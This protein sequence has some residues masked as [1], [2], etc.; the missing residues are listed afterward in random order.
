VRNKAPNW[1]DRE[2]RGG[3]KK[4]YPG[5]SPGARGGENV[6]IKIIFLQR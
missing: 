4:I 3:K 2:E 6:G 5:G 1:V